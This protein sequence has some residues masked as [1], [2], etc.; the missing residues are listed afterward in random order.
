MARVLLFAQNALNLSV[1]FVETHTCLFLQCCNNLR[2][3][4]HPEFLVALRRTQVKRKLQFA[5]LNRNLGGR[6]RVVVCPGIPALP[7]SKKYPLELGHVLFHL[8]FGNA[9]HISID[10]GIN[11]QSIAIKIVHAAIRLSVLRLTEQLSQLLA[12]LHTHVRR[13]PV[14]MCLPRIL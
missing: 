2:Q 11:A 4:L 14:C 6:R 3:I 8:L 9:L 1:I 13:Q 5:P 10:A 7:V 12:K